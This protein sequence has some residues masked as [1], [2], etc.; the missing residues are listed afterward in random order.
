MDEARAVRR[1]LVL[2]P[3]TC[4][5]FMATRPINTNPY[6]PTLLPK[7]GV[8]IFPPWLVISSPGNP[9]TRL[10]LRVLDAVE[11][12]AEG[13]GHDSDTCDR[14]EDDSSSNLLLACGEVEVVLHIEDGVDATTRLVEQAAPFTRARM[15]PTAACPTGAKNQ[16]SNQV[17]QPLP[18]CGQLI[19]LSSTH[20]GH[21]TASD[22]LAGKIYNL[23]N[24]RMVV[25]RTATEDIVIAH[26]SVSRDH[27]AITHNPDTGR[28]TIADLRS[29]NGVRVNGERCIAMELRT[30]DIVELGHIRMRFLSPDGEF[31]WLTD[32]PTPADPDHFLIVGSDVVVSRGEYLRIGARSFAI[33]E[34]AE[35]A[36]RGADLPLGGGRRIQAAMVMLVV[37]AATRASFT[38][39]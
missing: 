31:H 25:G 19:I 34:V 29:R 26:A 22:D 15:A 38:P 3:P 36:L 28:Y 2:L 11:I 27:A 1:S 39:S 7:S 37:A 20:D 4:L 16:R 5:P 6:Q 24:V 21:V 12:I 33:R 18:N 35:H 13:K 10:D 14:M 17:S 23:T 30:G 8:G 9:V 32:T